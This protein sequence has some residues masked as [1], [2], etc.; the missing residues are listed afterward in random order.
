MSQWKNKTYS[1]V[2]CYYEPFGKISY[3]RVVNCDRSEFWQIKLTIVYR[4]LFTLQQGCQT[5]SHQGP[6]L[7]I[8][9][10]A[11]LCDLLEKVSYTISYMISRAGNS[12]MYKIVLRAKF[13]CKAGR[14]FDTYALQ[15]FLNAAR[16]CFLRMWFFTRPVISKAIS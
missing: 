1:F 15:C 6:N 8:C 11:V 7:K 13:Y 16:H 4:R 2:N 10:V 3:L 12:S 5:Q 9:C 14:E